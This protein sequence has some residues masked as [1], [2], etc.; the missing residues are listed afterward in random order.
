ME[1]YSSSLTAAEKNIL[2]TIAANVP[3]CELHLHLDGSLSPGFICR[4]LLA[5]QL[6]LPEGVT[7]DGHGLR[8]YLHDMKANHVTKNDNRAEKNKNWGVFDFW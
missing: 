4:R 5:R 7:A 1:D 3:K 6:P 8:A 2:S